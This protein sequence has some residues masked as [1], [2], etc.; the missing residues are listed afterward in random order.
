MQTLIW[1]WKGVLDHIKEMLVQN[2]G[3][4]MMHPNIV[5]INPI[6]RNLLNSQLFMLCVL[7]IGNLLEE[8]VSNATSPLKATFWRL[9]FLLLKKMLE[10]LYI[11]L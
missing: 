11:C 8:V 2:K 5:K 6:R 10:D 3:N 7:I 4:I 1:R 9:K